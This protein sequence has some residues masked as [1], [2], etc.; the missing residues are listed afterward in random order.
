[1]SCLST[2]Y[3]EKSALTNST[4]AATIAPLSQ[5]TKVGIRTPSDK[6]H[7]RPLSTVVFLYPSK[8]QTAL[9]RVYSVMVGCI[10][11]P[12]K[13]LTGS[14]A[15]SSNLIHSATQRFEPMGGGYSHFKG[16]TA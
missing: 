7:N 2:D 14:F 1:M 13:R 4:M 9:C 11:R 8:I 6:G 12:L 16:A 15:G 10:E 5:K 3:Q